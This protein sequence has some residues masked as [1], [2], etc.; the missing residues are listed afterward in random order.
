MQSTE[1]GAQTVSYRMP[2][3]PAKALV[4]VACISVTYIFQSSKVDLK[5]KS[6]NHLLWR[7]WNFTKKF[8]KKKKLLLFNVTAML[9]RE[10]S[11][12]LQIGVENTTD[13]KAF[14]C[15]L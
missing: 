3:H 4:T 15:T 7:Q 10:A 6:T 2:W 13:M 5:V 8:K 14:A 11:I 9:N 12:Q 1:S